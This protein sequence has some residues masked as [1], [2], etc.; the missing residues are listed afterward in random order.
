MRTLIFSCAFVIALGGCTTK[1][2]P[3]NG[4]DG[5]TVTANGSGTGNGNGSGGGNGGGTSGGTTSDPASAFVGTWTPT[6]TLTLFCGSNTTGTKSAI[7]D[8][9]TFTELSSDE[10]ESSYGSCVLTANVSGSTA[11]ATAGQQCDEEDT[12]N[13]V[14][15]TV[16]ESTAQF[17][18]ESNGTT[19]QFYGTG[20]THEVISGTTYDCTY[21][22]SATYVKQGAP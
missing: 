2:G 4:T 14:P 3:G 22:Q 15:V 17:T 8:S 19:A 13:N 11:T 1:N 16:T 7:T 21:T 12:A 10:L 18:I 6:G 9:L 5:G 20:T